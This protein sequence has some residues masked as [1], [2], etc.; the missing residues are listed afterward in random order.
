[1][2]SGRSSDINSDTD[3]ADGNQA[4]TAWICSEGS[5]AELAANALK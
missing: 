2:E 5:R 1:M 3:G 4:F